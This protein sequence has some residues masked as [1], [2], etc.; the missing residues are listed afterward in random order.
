V[1]TLNDCIAFSELLPEEIEEICRHER[2]GF[3][4]AMA[5]G[6]NL[7]DQPWG[8]PAI[9]Q[10]LHDNLAEAMKTRHAAQCGKTMETYQDFQARHPGGIDRRQ[11][12]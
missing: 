11:R 2:L 9:R 7:L 1:L 8:E 12:R 10:I 4:S 3:M 5:K 6:R